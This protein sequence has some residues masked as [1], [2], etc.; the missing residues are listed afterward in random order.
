MNPIAESAG[1]L[2]DGHQEFVLATII[3]R[4]GSAPR[5]AGTRMIV[6]RGGRITGTIGGGLIEARVI[7]KAGEV[8]SSKCPEV[9]AFDMT[10]SDMA[11][12][13]MICGGRMEVLV[14]FI[15]PGGPAATVFKGWRDVQ[16][17]SAPCLF[18][19][20][21]RFAGDAVEAVNHCL[22]KDRKMIYGDL[23]SLPAA[24]EKHVHDYYGTAHLHSVAIEDT[25]V[26]LDPV[27]PAETV[28]LLGAG[29]VSQ[30]TARLA[31]SVGFRVQVVDDRETF[32]NA[33]R[34]PEADAIRVIADYGSAMD[35]LAIDESACV[36]IVTRGHLHDQTVLKQALRTRAGYIGMIG[37]RQKR[38]TIYAALLKQG[39]TGN[40][41]KRVHSPIGVDI[42]AET[43][44]EI[45]V[46]IVA[47]LIRVRAER[48]R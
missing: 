48:E 34:F 36:V 7:E 19:T 15:D 26:L 23:P 5:T 46:S 40:D 4:Q 3:S 31:V 30:P 27:L 29:H 33:D 16:D 22:F 13:D 17:A 9:V 20:L 35:G 47:E 44:A 32:A 18:L 25:L 10:P 24:V 11:A 41:L 1:R 42:G 6:E 8:L 45:A 39:F 14:E 2:L 21:L 37:S 28:F 43:P 38:D 12:M